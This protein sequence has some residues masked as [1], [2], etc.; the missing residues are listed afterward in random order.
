MYVRRTGDDTQHR[1]ML[2]PRRRRRRRRHSHHGHCAC[3]RLC[4]VGPAR[5]QAVSPASPQITTSRRQLSR[6]PT[7]VAT[8]SVS[9]S[10]RLG[11]AID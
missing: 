8:R 5:R 1:L 10:F 4:A 9:Q 3:R 11:S 6:S 7:T 2:D